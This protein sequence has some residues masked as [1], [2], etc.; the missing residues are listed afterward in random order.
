MTIEW[1]YTFEE[2]LD[3]GVL[4]VAGYLGPDA[5]HRFLGAVDWSVVR[6]AGPVVV[7]LA[8][9]RAWSAEGRQAIA[10]A[11]RCLGAH[12]RSLELAAIPSRGVLL[13]DDDG[14][15]ISVHPDLSTALAAHAVCPGDGRRG[16]RA[17]G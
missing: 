9:L 11:A 4:S 2:D 8:E 13:L 15:H 16:Q 1:R 14:P 3:V 6:G 17:D 12:G 5:V 7:D 10:E